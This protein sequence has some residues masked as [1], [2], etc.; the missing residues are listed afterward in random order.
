MVL[1]PGPAPTAT[2]DTDDE[3]PAARLAGLYRRLRP[4]ATASTERAQARLAAA[5]G[6][7]PALSSGWRLRQL[8]EARAAIDAA[9]DESVL[10]MRSEG[11]TWNDVAHALGCP[12][13][14]AYARYRSARERVVA[15]L[16]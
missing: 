4:G 12:R 11:A 9:I 13:G 7:G 5:A 2:T 16:P 1:P 10:A 15:N 8:L 6:A 3:G 14:T